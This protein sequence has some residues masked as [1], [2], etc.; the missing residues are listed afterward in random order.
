MDEKLV[1]FVGTKIVLGKPMSRNEFDFKYHDVKHSSDDNDQE[2]FLVVYSN[3][4]E[5]TYDSWS[6]K[7]TFKN[8]YREL[9]EGEADFVRVYKP[10]ETTN[11]A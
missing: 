3:P 2:G 5:T 7:E 10:A 1:P 11:K 9:T 8:C 4:D 6:P